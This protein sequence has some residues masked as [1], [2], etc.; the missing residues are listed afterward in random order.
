MATRIHNLQDKPKPSKYRAVKTSVDGCVFDSKA[1]AARYG[2]NKIRVR[3][4]E[5]AYFLRQV[6][7]HLPG[8]VVYR[9]DFLEVSPDGCL[10][11]V[12]VKGFLT[13]HCKDKIKITEAAYPVKIRLVKCTNLARMS[14]KDYSDG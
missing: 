6:P 5:L 13:P 8:G 4:G 2:L 7:F 11:Y 14:F 1:E 9:V 12:D 10:E 3:Q